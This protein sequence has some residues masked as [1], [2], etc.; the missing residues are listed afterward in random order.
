[1]AGGGGGAGDAGDDAPAEGFICP[2]CM[3]G[4]LNPD[5]LQQHFE[6]EHT[7]TPPTSFNGASSGG[8]G[9]NI[10]QNYACKHIIYIILPLI[11]N[12]VVFYLYNLFDMLHNLNQNKSQ[13]IK[14]HR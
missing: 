11:I 14:R 3:K 6:T 12:I 8:G 5:V 13:S 10:F 4:F 9:K 1:M 2:M 7:D